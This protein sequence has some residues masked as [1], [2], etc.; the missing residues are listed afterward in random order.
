MVIFSGSGVA[1]FVPRDP[2]IHRNALPSIIVR[3]IP[4]RKSML[5]WDEAVKAGMTAKLPMEISDEEMRQ[6]MQNFLEAKA[7][8]KGTFATIDSFSE[9]VSSDS[10]DGAEITDLQ[11]T[12]ERTAEGLHKATAKLKPK[13]SSLLTGLLKLNPEAGKG[14][15]ADIMEVGGPRLT[16]K[17][18]GEVEVPTGVKRDIDL[19]GLYRSLG[20]RAK[21][22]PEHKLDPILAQELDKNKKEGE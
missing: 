3:S 22:R 6:R 15:T 16:P 9:F 8:G 19:L 17:R 1:P 13:P 2:E 11:L 20:G 7:E 12:G 10:A 18:E 4:E 5:T 21:L 14:M